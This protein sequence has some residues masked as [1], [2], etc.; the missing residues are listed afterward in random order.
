MR[1]VI[2]CGGIG[3]RMKGYSFPKPLNM[4]HGKPAI[5]FSLANIPE[6]FRCFHFIY[7]SHLKE[8]NFE[9]IVVNLF[10]NRSCTFVCIDYFTRGPV[11]TAWLGVEGLPEDEPILFLDNDNIYHFP[12]DF[13]MNQ[14]TAFLGCCQDITGS[15]AFSFIQHDGTYVKSIAEKLR[16]S[17]TYC[18]GVYG[19]RSK[20]QFQTTALNILESA[21]GKEVYMSHLFDHLL[22][23]NEKVRFIEFGSQST[24]IGSLRELGSGDSVPLPKMRICFDLD[25][26]LVTYPTVPGDYTTVK[27]IERMISLSRRLHSEGHT[28]IIYTARRMA[29]H[30]CNVGSVLKDI[31]KLT[32]DTLDKFGIEY[33]EIIFG[34]PIA[35]IY[36]DDRAVNPYRNDMASMGLFDTEK[37]EE[38]MN[39]LPP[40]KHNSLTLKDNKIV[41]TGPSIL[42]RGQAFFYKH[43]PQTIPFFPNHYACKDDGNIVQI[44]MEYIRGISLFHLLKHRLFTTHHLDRIFHIINVLHNTPTSVKQPTIEQVAIAYIDKF[45]KRLADKTIYPF[46]DTYQRFNLYM[47]ALVEYTRSTRLISVPIIHGDFWLSNMMITFSGEIKCFDMRG[48]IGDFLTLGGDPLYD[49]AKLYQSLVGYDCCLWN[50]RYDSDYKDMLLN[51]FRMKVG[52]KFQDIKMISTVLMM[53]SLHAIESTT[54]RVRVWEWLK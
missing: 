41:K 18:V 3:E 14:D 7:S 37:L 12:S 39:Q 13:S 47:D 15:S 49:Y 33:D 1:L 31:G 30:K 6:A 52:N 16:I 10:S 32:F 9:E 42:L 44:D 34:K 40:N 54:D 23:N 5:A 28:I 26:T 45:A 43:Y 38:I 4:I 27:P 25:N 17:D 19:F 2:L 11:E 53:G 8:Y 24:H 35:D 51:H 29:T 48:L 21:N 46:E 50:C 22:K 20:Q 36:I